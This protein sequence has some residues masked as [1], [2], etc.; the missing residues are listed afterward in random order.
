[1]ERLQRIPFLRLL[2]PLLIGIIAQYYFHIDS[3]LSIILLLTGLGVMLFS[4]F[5][6]IKKQFGYRWIYG[7]GV[8]IFLFSIGLFSTQT[9]Q[10]KSAFIF[11]DIHELYDVTIT[12]IPQEKP[13]TFAFRTEIAELNKKIVCY[14]PK[15]SL[16]RE[17]T[18]GDHIIIFSKVARFKNMGN[19]GEFDYARYMYNKGYAGY[20]FVWSDRWEK[21]EDISSPGLFINAAKCRQKILNFYSSLNLNN[22]EYAILSALTLGYKDTLNDDLAESFR[23]TGT[24]H[25][26]AV[27][28]MHIAII[29]FIIL[30]LLAFIP[31]NSRYSWL[32]PTI[33]I[34]LLWTYAFI[35]GFPP[36]AVRAC[37]MLTMFCI[38]Q[39]VGKRT[40]SL[41]T[42]FAT[43][44][45]MLLWNPFWLFDPG[46]QL[47]FAAVL[48]MLLLLPLFSKWI[49]IEN[50]YLRYIW[51]IFIVSL[52]AQIGTLPLCLYYFGTFPTYFFL[53]NLLI[54]PLISIIICNAIFM[55]IFG[56]LSSISIPAA[57]LLLDIS[58]KLYTTLVWVITHTIHFF[59]NLPLAQI[60]N[61]K[62]S[63]T[64]LFLSWGI[65][66]SFIYFGI[67]RKPKALVSGLTCSII[68]ML[69][70]LYSRFE[71]KN[72]LTVLNNKQSPQI[73]YYIEH[74]RF[75]L[76]DIPDNK[77]LWLNG[78][79]YLILT[80]DTWKEMS[81]KN[82]LDIDYLHLIGNN[83]IS[84]YSV[85]KKFNI[86]KIILDGSLSTK[87]L[88]RF[89]LECEKLRIPYYDVSENGV[90]RIFF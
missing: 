2:L 58:I 81:T 79:K 82:K 3:R 1:M 32:K 84:L 34:V 12:D 67:R 37:S 53:A 54:I 77:L 9:R 47:S 16:S 63:F 26:L 80:N 48:S 35:I 76:T 88:K 40:Y 75:A 46:F 14:L 8:Y 38:S 61:I 23:A 36:S 86:K 56:C 29:Y 10:F 20:T 66:I 85:N 83:Q 33:T 15:D 31:E 11:P 39:I 68:F 6:P 51:N 50:K 64:A 43:A 25:I 70:P 65:I 52:V 57:T 62:I 22:N 13:N 72:T 19:P 4:Y 59:E 55:L 18:V 87:S 21:A 7:I 41:N 60:Q 27:S 73:T 69:I 30:L 44:F 71:N 89:V 17:L 49:R 5:I 42:L 24:A 78:Q 45:L 28:G 90:L 74:K